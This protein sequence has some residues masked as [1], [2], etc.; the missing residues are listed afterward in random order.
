MVARR[1]ALLAAPGLALAGAIQAQPR[2][3]F[4][5]GVASG[6]PTPSGVVLWTRLAPEPLRPDGGMQAP[7]PVDWV[8]AED[9]GLRRIVARGQEMA[10][11]EEAH[12]VH[13]EVAGLRPGRDYWYR[14][15]AMGAASPVGTDTPGTPITGM[16]KDTAWARMMRS[17]SALPCRSRP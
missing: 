7:V 14:F 17:I 9:P 13:A 1:T 3:P 5:L 6:E 12:S 11:A 2:A 15:M 10:V 16:A 4:T 8:V